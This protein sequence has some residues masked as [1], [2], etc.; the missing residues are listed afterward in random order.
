LALAGFPDIM[1]I[2]RTKAAELFILNSLFI[3]GLS[4]LPISSVIPYLTIISDKTKKGNKEGKILFFHICKEKETEFKI[5]LDSARIS[6]QIKIKIK[7]IITV[8]HFLIKFT[9]F[10]YPI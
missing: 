9:L 8:V 2:T 10:V 7:I 6:M 3:K 4:K 1:L 5:D